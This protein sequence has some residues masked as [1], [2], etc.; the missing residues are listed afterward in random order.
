VSFA[1]GLRSF[2]LGCVSRRLIEIL[3]TVR[4]RVVTADV[5]V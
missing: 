4:E 5:V 3:V 2:V 1:L